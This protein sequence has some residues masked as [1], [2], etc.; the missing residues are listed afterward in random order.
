V[1]D[2]PVP[3]NLR[4]VRS[5]VGLCSYY[6]RFVKDFARISSP[7]HALTKKNASFQWDDE[8]QEAFKALKGALTSAP[9]LAMPDDE[10]AFV[11]DT[12]AS[13]SEIGA[14]L[15]Q[16]KAGVE[17]VVAYASRK[18]SKAEC[19]Y[20]ATRKELHAVVSFIKYFKHFLLGCHFVVR[21]DHAALQW[22]WKIPE[23]VGQQARWIGFL[24]EF[25]FDMVHRP[26]GHHVNADALSRIPCRSDEDNC[27][28]IVQMNQQP[29]RL[30]DDKSSCDAR[31]AGD[32]TFDLDQPMGTELEED[33]EVT[34]ESLTAVIPGVQNDSDEAGMIVSNAGILDWS[35]AE[36]TLAQQADQDVGV[37][38]TMLSSNIVKPPS[39]EV[40]VYGATCKSLLHQWERLI[41]RDGVMYRRFYSCDGVPSFF[42]TRGTVRV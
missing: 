11:L 33:L 19:N 40:A 36:I 16:K 1:A 17:H 15:S 28:P 23:P 20:S 29:E 27:R 8:C 2:W 3:V 41:L 10:S 21:T 25:D 39:S 9:V 31:D 13:H 32:G 6:R 24:G 34:V 7:L 12:D 14:V 26:G 30:V 5:F 18:M 4:E 38:S 22:L 35:S 42:A 37:I